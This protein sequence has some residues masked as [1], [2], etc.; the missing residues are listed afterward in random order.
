MQ[1][2]DSGSEISICYSDLELSRVELYSA[3]GYGTSEPQEDALALINRLLTEAEKV[4]RPRAGFRILDGAVEGPRLRLSGSWFAPGGIISHF[5]KGC[6]VFSI[7]LATVG[8]EMDEWIQSYRVS[9]DVM[10][11][12]VAD[13]IGSVVAE[14]VV[15]KTKK[16]LAQRVAQEGCSIT[17]SYSPGYCGWHVREQQ[18]LFALLPKDFCGVTLA[19]S[20]LMLPLKSVSSVVGVG[21]EVVSQPYR[22]DVC[23]KKDC[24]RR[25]D[26]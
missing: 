19:D 12:F 17:N 7:I 18:A 13:G 3:L 8:L 10:E 14:A 15:D 22:C 1:T 6:D 4:C 20:S 9:G 26:S 2:S 23:R 11:A 24:F 21:R 5:L 16:V 25:K